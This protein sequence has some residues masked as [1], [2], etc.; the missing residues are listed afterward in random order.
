VPLPDINLDDLRFQR[1]L[2]DEARKRIV[3]YAPEW[4]EYNVSDPGITLIELFAWMTEM[5][6]YRLNR[7]PEKN[8]V[9]FLEM[10]GVRLG[11]AHSSRALLTFRLSA[12][13]PLSPTDETVAF[14]PRGLEIATQETPTAPQVIFTVDEPLSIQPP[15]V[16]E[17]R[18]L[19]QFNVNWVDSVA[20]FLAFRQDP[21]VKGATFYIGFN[22]D[23]KLALHI[24]RLTFACDRTEAYGVRR[25]DPP[26]VWEVSTGGGSWEEIIP[27]RLPGEQDTTGGLNNELGTMTFYLPEKT[28]PDFVQGLGA[29]WIRCRY[30]G[31]R[32]GQGT[33]S[34]SP[35]IRR[36]TAHAL[37]ASTYAS[38]AVYQGAEDLGVSNGDA[39][40]VFHLR[41]SPVL[42]L[43]QGESLEVEETREGFPTWVPWQR[44]EDFSQSDEFSRHYTFDTST[45][46]IRLGPVIR[47]SNGAMRAY[48]RVPHVGARLRMSRYRHGGGSSGNVPAN[49]ITVMRSAVPYIDRVYNLAAA[50]GGLDPETLDGAMMRARGE[51]RAQ[52]RAVTAEDYENLAMRADRSLARAKCLAPGSTA[53]L[54]PP[55]MLELLLVPAAQDSVALGDFSRLA[56]DTPLLNS[57]Q[58]YLD[59]Y[60]LLTTTLNLR[61]PRYIGVRVKVRVV[62]N[63]L[64]PAD[65]AQT[66]VVEALRKYLAPLPPPHGDVLLPD[67]ADESRW[68]GWP[69]GKSLF[70]AEVYALVQRVR[71]VR[72][73]LD[74]QL[75][76]R[77]M[78]LTRER[79]AL[80]G[81]EAYAAA[82][83]RSGP[84]PEP[85]AVNGNVLTIPADGL[86]CSLD[87]VV[88]VVSL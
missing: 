47:Q 67:P 21:P 2:V 50:Y 34:Q 40:Q 85:I 10:L 75:E 58:Q 23:D 72:H 28:R 86:I 87:H 71:G 48:G 6:T 73:V 74:V 8:Y 49:R 16:T 66:R 76:S 46:E 38:N 65:V 17:L 42:P 44:V 7:V 1:D 24:L 33:Y 12:P 62:A 61:E 81:L 32:E 51:L 88:E 14:I 84:T 22:P 9:R 4:T 45:G 3:R 11:P 63:D 83:A 27:S 5:I 53:S 26:L 52:D 15:H 43:R 37:G 70:V 18:V 30:E 36:V 35:R 78:D 59:Q 79:A 57:V 55:G 31:R 29:T 54:L 13:F 77:P 56:V 64:T 60:R 41:A 39:G 20:P 69:F 68:Q 80:G 82:V 19:D 25:D